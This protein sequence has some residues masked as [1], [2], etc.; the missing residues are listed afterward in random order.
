MR[1]VLPRLWAKGRMSESGMNITTDI[2]SPSAVL[3]FWIWLCPMLVF[4]VYFRQTPIT[5]SPSKGISQ[6]GFIYYFTVTGG[7]TEAWAWYYKSFDCALLSL[8]AFLYSLYAIDTVCRVWRL[9]FSPLG[10]PPFIY[11]VNIYFMYTH[12][13]NIFKCI[14]KWSIVI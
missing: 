4:V 5:S 14:N 3:V 6:T 10:L 1:N 2:L 9:L 8:W 13:V 11:I 12:F 7:A